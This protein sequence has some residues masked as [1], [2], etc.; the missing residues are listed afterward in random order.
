M[1]EGLADLVRL[2]IVTMLTMVTMATLWASVTM[3]TQVSYLSRAP[4]TIYSS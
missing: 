3:D 2:V 4:L 1:N